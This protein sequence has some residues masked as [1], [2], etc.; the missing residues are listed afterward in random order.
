MSGMTFNASQ[1]LVLWK[2]R[3]RYRK[4]QVRHAKSATARAKWAKLLNE[5]NAMVAK[6]TKQTAPKKPTGISQHGIDMIARFEGGQSRDGLFHAY[7]DA[8]GHVWT[9]GHGQTHG[10]TQYTGP[11]TKKQADADLKKSFDRDYAPAVRACNLPTQGWFDA[12]ASFVWNCG[13]GTISSGSHLGSLLRQGQYEAA[14]AVM[15]QWNKAGGQ[16]L[17]GLTT[18][19]QAEIALSRT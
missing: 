18:R 6:R 11:W 17:P 7:W 19:R 1:S 15:A 9:I 8:Y 5:A 16:V 3:Q 12:I 14:R 10:V 13:P 4:V 2:A